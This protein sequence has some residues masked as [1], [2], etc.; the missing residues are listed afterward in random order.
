MHRAALEIYQNM[1]ASGV[2]TAREWL[3]QNFAGAREGARWI[4]LWTTA[5]QS[6]FVIGQASARGDAAFIGVLSSDDIL[7]LSLSLRRLASYLY[8]TRT[9]DK[10]GAAHILGVRPPG[11]TTDVA[12][13]W[14]V[15]SATAHSKAEFQ[16]GERV[17][18]L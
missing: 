9:H 3:S 17:L 10:T 7:E 18:K 16:R 13:G 6:D 5:A 1:R 4:D 8:V 15:D 12:P 14:L 2:A 11:M